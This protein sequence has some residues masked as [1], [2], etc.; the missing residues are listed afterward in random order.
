MVGW[1]GVSAVVLFLFSNIRNMGTGSGYVY[2]LIAPVCIAVILTTTKN[3]FDA[4]LVRRSAYYLLA[5][6]AYFLFKVLIDVTEVAELR[7]IT[8][9]TSGGL[10]FALLLGLIVSLGSDLGFRRGHGQVLNAAATLL[11]L[12]LA[13]SLSFVTY[14]THLAFVREDLFLVDLDQRKYQR[15]GDFAVIVAIIASLQIAKLFRGTQLNGILMRALASMAFLAYMLTVFLLLISS[16][17]I[18]S[19]KG[20]AVT[21][22]I[23]AGTTIWIFRP[24]GANQRWATVLVPGSINAVGVFFSSTPR[25]VVNGALFGV[26][27]IA[28]AALLF[29]VTALEPQHFRIFGFSNERIGGHSFVGRF[30]LLT[31][32][33]LTQLAINPM[34]GNL[35]ADSLTTG[36]GT[37]AHSLI[38]ILSHLGIVGALLF[39]A[40]LAALCKEL[41]RANRYT[42]RIY[43]DI[44]VG[45]FRII[46]IS[47]LL[48][49]SLLA[50]FFTWMPLWFAFGLLCP[51]LLIQGSKV[52]RNSNAETSHA[53]CGRR[54]PAGSD[55][56]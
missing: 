10:V 36:K 50:T 38:S 1:L 25:L 23:A 21:L 14:K 30:Q 29:A 6:L 42:A 48:L 5:F 33:F 4:V 53:I 54:P 31:N 22:A 43:G 9:G 24:S 47:I 46:I 35:N 32:N 26:A 12:L 37:Y 20:F 13:L 56:C 7:A 28:I 39:S 34:F 18:G 19:N 27:I 41:R 44:E 3:L 15:P 16:Q 45:V 8:I 55:P 11:F 51:P 17:L 2:L 52:S 49:F 40:Y